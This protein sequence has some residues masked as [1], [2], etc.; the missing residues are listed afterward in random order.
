MQ[1]DLDSVRVFLSNYFD[2]EGWVNK[3]VRCVEIFIVLF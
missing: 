3:I 2:V 1:V